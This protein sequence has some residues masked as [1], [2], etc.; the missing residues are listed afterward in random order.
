M[1]Q[2]IGGIG[3]TF[4]FNSASEDRLET[5]EWSVGPTVALARVLDTWVSGVVVSTLW[6]FAG[7]AR[8]RRVNQF[9]LSPFVIYNFV[10]GWYL[11][12]RPVIVANW[13]R[14]SRNRWRVPIGGGVGKVLFR[15]AKRPMNLVLQGFH[16]L[17]DQISPLIGP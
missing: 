7:D 14:A 17:K 16:S 13:E 8:P 5:W 15:G 1:L 11:T 12:S 6:S 4:I 9:S 10:N 3:P 2:S